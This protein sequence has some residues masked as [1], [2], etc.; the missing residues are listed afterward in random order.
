MKVGVM[1]LKKLAKIGVNANEFILPR[2]KTQGWQAK[3]MMRKKRGRVVAG[4]GG[5]GEKLE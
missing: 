1:L 3:K 5:K 2:C 4:V